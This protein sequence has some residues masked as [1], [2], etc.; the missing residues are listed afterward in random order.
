MRKV[1]GGLGAAV[2]AQ[3]RT[4]RSRRGRSVCGNGPLLTLPQGTFFAAKLQRRA[5]NDANQKAKPIGNLHRADHDP[6]PEI[7]LT[8][9]YLSGLF[10]DKVAIDQPGIYTESPV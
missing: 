9:Q 5:P 2:V 8:V 7:L 4:P 1:L 3:S 6:D 10:E